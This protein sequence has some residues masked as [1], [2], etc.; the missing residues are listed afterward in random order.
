MSV[1]D[2]VSIIGLIILGGGL[3]ATWIRN[4]R[5]QSRELGKFEST[6]VSIQNELTEIK[7]E[8]KNG[9]YGLVALNN[10]MGK[11][12][13]HCAEVSTDLAVRVKSSE[14]SIEDIEH[15]MKRR[16]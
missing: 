6:Q 4:G 16:R 1:A 7:N 12:E 5:K 13:T 15:E 3:A 8:I 10:K 11:F 14:Q 2:L 9:E